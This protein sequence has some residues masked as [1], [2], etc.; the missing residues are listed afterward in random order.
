MTKFI[1]LVETG[2][3]FPKDLARQY[4]VWTAPM[5]VSFGGE[6]KD[7]G[8]F[9]VEDIYRFFEQTG[10]LTKTSGCTPGDFEKVFDEIRREYPEHHILHLA[11]SAATTC[12]YQSAIIAAEGRE[13]ITSVDVKHVSAGQ[14][15]VTLLVARYI[16]ENPDCTVEQV[17]EKAKEYAEKVKMGFFPGDL[18]YLKAGGRVSN[19]AYLGAKI[20]SLNPLIELKDGHLNA[21]K[22]YRGRMDKVALKLLQEFAEQY[23]LGRD[24]L[25]FV[26]S[27][28]LS[29]QIKQAA[30]AMATEMGF[31]EIFWVQTGGVVTTHCGPGGFGVC[32]VSE[33]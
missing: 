15:L 1:L 30:N 5:H 28:G 9:P 6:T 13:N 10:T 25:A 16:E 24:V 18:A 33:L 26:Y 32:G 31:R 19:A 7:D 20:L 22:K 11:Y 23:K 27:A 3:D 17:V 8:T 29:E 12:S 2:A 4:G 14:S 21:T